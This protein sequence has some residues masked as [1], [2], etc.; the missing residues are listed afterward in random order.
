MR[1][2]FPAFCCCWGLQ[3]CCL[4][5]AGG[6]LGNSAATAWQEKG[7]GEILLEIQQDP[8]WER[9]PSSGAQPDSLSDLFWLLWV[10]LHGSALPSLPRFWDVLP[11][12]GGPCLPRCCLHLSF[13]PDK[14]F[15]F[16]GDED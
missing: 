3:P 13:P 12:W 5:K 6:E 2:N 10:V 7:L 9:H 8:P 4:P 11:A 14:N 15:F 16:G 1:E